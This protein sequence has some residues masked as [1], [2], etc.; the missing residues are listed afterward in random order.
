LG[1]VLDRAVGPRGFNRYVYA[2]PMGFLFDLSRWALPGYADRDA[3]IAFRCL[4][5]PW[6]RIRDE[7]RVCTCQFGDLQNEKPNRTSADNRHAGCDSQSSQVH[8]V[9]CDAKRLEE[10]GLDIVQFPRDRK[11]GT[12]WH[13]HVFAQAASVRKISAEMQI[14]AKIWMA[15]FA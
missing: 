4:E 13:V 10:S 7:Y 11:A 14:S 15:V 12:G 8:R 1:R 3:T 6:K 5:A 9:Q 2:S